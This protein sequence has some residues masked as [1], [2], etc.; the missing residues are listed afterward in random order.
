MAITLA[1][2]PDV[3]TTAAPHT[4]F[5]CRAQAAAFGPAL[6]WTPAEDWPVKLVAGA[7]LSNLT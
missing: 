2:D 5:R 6:T 7:V 4:R 3:Q 1:V